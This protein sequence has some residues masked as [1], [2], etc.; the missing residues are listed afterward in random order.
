MRMK[1]FIP[2]AAIVLLAVIL[3]IGY[4]MDPTPLNVNKLVGS[5]EGYNGR[6][7]TVEAIYVSGGEGTLLTEYVTSLGTGSTREL[8]PV[9]E[10]IWFD[11]TL[12]PELQGQLHEITSPAGETSYYGKL[13]VTGLFESGDSYGPVNQFKYRLTAEKVKALDWTPPE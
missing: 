2:I 1:V 6:T 8:K 7:V 5:A 12:P 10:S 13:K 4:G 3:W 11:G 9:G